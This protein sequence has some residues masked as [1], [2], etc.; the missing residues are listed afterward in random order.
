[1]QIVLTRFTSLTNYGHIGPKT[2]LYLLIDPGK[3]G[4]FWYLNALFFIGVL[5]VLL[6]SVLKLP[7]PAQI[8]LGL[9]FFCISAYIHVNELNG[10]I[11]LY[12]FE[13]YIFFALGD[14]ISE[15]MFD[16]GNIE[17]FSSWKTFFPLLILFSAV[18]YYCAKLILQPHPEG[19]YYVEHKLPFLFLAES[20]I[21]CII[22][23]NF[24]F[25]LQRY[26]ALKFLRVVGFHS[27]FIYCMQIVV[28]QSARII[29]MNGLHLTYVP[30]LIFAIWGAGVILPIFIYNYCLKHKMWWLFTFRKPEKQVEYLRYQNIF[31]PKRF[32]DRARLRQQKETRALEEVLD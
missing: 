28:M 27:L 5:Y 7:T 3:T 23:L 18:Q 4:H 17:R 12:I 31:R 30:V 32:V 6:K 21:G 19:M 16:P 11:L 25:L 1:M 10:G 9:V 29:L 24:S 15:S 26:K 13:Y 2:Y 22:S 20:L 8:A 14:F